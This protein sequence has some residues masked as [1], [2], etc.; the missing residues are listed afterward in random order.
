MNLAQFAIPGHPQAYY[1]P[2]F[3]NE[4][5]EKYLIRKVSIRLGC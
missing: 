4:D 5:E 1:I 2:N 3:V